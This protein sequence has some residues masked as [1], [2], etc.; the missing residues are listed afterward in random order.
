MSANFTQA[1]IINPS[2]SDASYKP[3]N[4]EYNIVKVKVLSIFNNNFETFY[5]FLKGYPPPTYFN[6]PNQQQPC[7]N[8][9]APVQQQTPILAAP[10]QQQ[11]LILAA[12]VQQKTSL[13]ESMY[14]IDSVF[15]YFYYFTVQFSCTNTTKSCI[16][17]KCN[18][19][20]FF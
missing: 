14:D 7:L 6:Y 20:S 19:Y 13:P 5:I 11:T 2:S 17:T 18:S 10:V 8:L 12:P 3:T 16:R 1:I 4:K 9:A 15:Y